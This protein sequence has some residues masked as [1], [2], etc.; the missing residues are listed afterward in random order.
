MSP[1]LVLYF[2]GLLGTLREGGFSYDLA[3]EVGP[4]V[5]ARSCFIPMTILATRQTTPC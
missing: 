1:I 2:E 5:S 3:Q 4:R